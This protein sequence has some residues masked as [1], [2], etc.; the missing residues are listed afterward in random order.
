ME[1]ASRLFKRIQARTS[2]SQAVVVILLAGMLV[3]LP[4]AIN[5]A[6]WLEDTSI[7]W[8]TG[9]YSALVGVLVAYLIRKPVVAVLLIV[10]SGAVISPLVQGNLLP[11]FKPAYQELALVEQWLR[12]CIRQAI[13][14]IADPAITIVYLPRPPILP[15]WQAALE[16]L[17]LY[18]WNLQSDWP[19][20]LMPGGRKGS[21]VLLGTLIRWLIW[22]VTGLL[23]WL[24]AHDK[25]PWIS[26][27]LVI[28]LLLLNAF[29]KDGGF[30]WLT[31]GT[32]IGLVL[33]SSNALQQVEGRW[34]DRLL[35]YGM[36]GD[37]LIWGVVAVLVSTL[38]MTGSTWLTSQEFA[39]WVDEI[40]PRKEPEAAET[41]S[42][43]TA[44]VREMSVW[45][46]SH[47]LGA[48]PEVLDLEVMTVHLAE[49]SEYRLYWRGIV[50]NQYTGLGWIRQSYAVANPLTPLNPETLDPPDHYTFIRQTFRFDYPVSTVYAAGRPVRVSTPTVSRWVDAAGS[51]L[52][53]LSTSFPIAAYE[54]QS[55]QPVAT[56]DELRAS[57]GKPYP[58]WVTRS[59]LGLPTDLPEHIASFAEAVTAEQETTYDKALALQ[60]MLRSYEYT[61]DLDQPPTDRDVVDYYLFD[62]QRGYCDY[63]ATA[64]VVLARTLGIPARL[65]SGFAMGTYTPEI[66]AYR[67]VY[68]DTHAWPELYFPD[69]GWIIFEPTA[70]YPEPTAGLDNQNLQLPSLNSILAE[71]EEEQQAE[72]AEE[73]EFKLALPWY[74][75]GGPIIL[76][77]AVGQIVMM[78]IAIRRSRLRRMEPGRLVEALY[79]MILK[80]G[81]R[82]GIELSETRTP[83]E[84]LDALK[85]VLA[86]RMKIAPRWGGDWKKRRDWLLRDVTEIFLLYTEHCYSPRTVQRSQADDVFALWPF[87]IRSLWQFWL[88]GVLYPRKLDDR[89]PGAALEP[90]G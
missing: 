82:M 81:Q 26:T 54:V 40:N 67:V 12:V 10:I 71:M 75:W 30:L 49:Q 62:L 61:L 6:G 74:V 2:L 17:S 8:I 20:K 59:Y 48:G 47:L 60:Q 70:A 4:I 86:E 15:E 89:R 14:M 29:Y 13:H 73:A 38:V 55:W 72:L 77:G 44:S 23:I 84:Y 45:P 18:A 22:T 16:R 33:I 34:P 35:P 7:V 36:A 80:A 68:G 83:N 21:Q 53:Y 87:V 90:A 69:Y 11:P 41:A 37:W 42:A 57:D 24:T 46:V 88:V 43:G 63:S 28:G 19:I 31:V 50:Y 51:D 3:C 65:A 9:V 76:V 39:D 78:V 58:E 79:G 52:V 56:P 64:M 25:S 5:Q 32:T 1:L 27:F 66:D 85:G